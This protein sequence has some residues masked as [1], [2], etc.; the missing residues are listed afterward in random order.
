MAKNKS[1]DK[2]KVEQ[3]AE[4][5]TAQSKVNRAEEADAEAGAREKAKKEKKASKRSKKS[6]KAVNLVGAE[7]VNSLKIEKA[8]GWQRI[9][10]ILMSKRLRKIVWA[11]IRTVLLTGLCFLI[12]YPLITQ[13]ITSLKTEQDMFDSTVIFIPRTLNVNNYIVMWN[14]MRAGTLLVNSLLS[15]LGL[16]LLQMV[17]CTFVAYGLARFKFKGRGLVFAL[18]ILTLVIPIQLLAD[19]MK[20]R[21]KNFDVL[22]LFAMNS[23]Y[24]YT[25]GAGLNLVGS[26]W[27]FI[28][29]SAT[30]VMYRNGLYIFLL[31]QYFKN[32]PKELE[33]A[34]YIDGAS[35]FRTFWQIMLP[36]ALPLL[37]TVFLFAFVFQY[38]DAWYLKMLYPSADVMANKISQAGYTY[39]TQILKK[40]GDDIAVKTIFDG[41]SLV[42]H[43]CPLIILYVFC[44]QFFVQ[45][46]ERSGMV[47]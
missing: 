29:M 19:A 30:A 18:V 26:W 5:M 20:M 31:R 46:I 2:D 35:T 16:G 21:F 22:T 44:Q 42:L 7:E 4:E 3:Q 41:V 6:E 10:Q 1:K 33:D 12:L 13:L 43:V 25:E 8:K 9:K 38:N 28:A 34:S 32:Q 14:H 27:I 24:L 36:S 40:A 17:S 23:K 11:V 37:I 39:V 15:S 45:S 47:G